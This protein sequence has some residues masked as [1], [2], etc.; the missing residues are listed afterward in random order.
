MGRANTTIFEIMEGFES[1]K[2][3]LYIPVDA[4]DED[5]LR[6]SEWFNDLAKHK[7]YT[8]GDFFKYFKA[9]RYSNDYGTYAFLNLESSIVSRCV[10]DG[11]T[12]GYFTRSEDRSSIQPMT[13]EEFISCIDDEHINN[14]MESEFEM[15]FGGE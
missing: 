12:E 9:L 6:I 15:V 4:R 10:Y 2:L 5:L 11:A 3:R 8:D 14:E 7:P 1:G 13:I